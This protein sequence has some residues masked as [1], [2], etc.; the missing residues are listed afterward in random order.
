MTTTEKYYHPHE[1]IERESQHLVKDSHQPVVVQ[2]E[3]MSK[4]KLN[5]FNPDEVI[6]E[7]GG[8]AM[9]LYELFMGPLEV[10]KP[11][12]MDGVKGV[13][14]FLN[15]VWR[16]VI[17][18]FS[19]EINGKINATE[20]ETEPELHKS[21]HKTIKKV[22]DDTADLRFNTAI[23]QMMIFVNDATNSRTLPQKILEKFLVILSPYAPHICEELWQ[24][25]GGQDFI[26]RESW[27]S[28]D[29][30]L[31]IE[32]TITLIVQVNGRLRDRI[33]VPRGTVANKLEELALQA[34]PIQKYLKGKQVVKVVTVPDRL[35][36]I[37][38]K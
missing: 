18:E 37:V 24:R 33:C 19:G 27:P 28:Y 29:E 30:A 3:K 26:A 12:Q 32:E 34:A 10:T 8:D 6:D 15:R 36:N 21:L 7:Y 31:C 14:N 1:I 11:W 35:V 9:R 4:S 13:H 22:G 17:D 2:I 5:V 25:L 20:P 16:L 23:A 38:V